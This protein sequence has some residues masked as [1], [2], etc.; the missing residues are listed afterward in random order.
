VHERLK[1]VANHR[2]ISYR[3]FILEADL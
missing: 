2:Q 1:W 3:D